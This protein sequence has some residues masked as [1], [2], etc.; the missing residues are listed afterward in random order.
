MDPIP[1]HLLSCSVPQFCLCP[2][3]PVALVSP[4]LHPAPSCV[5]AT[6]WQF[7]QWQNSRQGRSWWFHQCHG[8]TLTACP[9]RWD[10]PLTPPIGQDSAPVPRE[11]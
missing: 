9:H 7:W 10:P 3:P 4:K 8:H 11:A 1:G 2:S 5:P 6:A